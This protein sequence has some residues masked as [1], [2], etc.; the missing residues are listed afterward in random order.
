MGVLNRL[1]WL[2]QAVRR[3]QKRTTVGGGGVPPSAHAETHEDGGT[4]EIDILALAGYPDPLD[5]SVVL[6]G[7]RTFGPALGASGAGQYVPS[8]NGDG[9]VSVNSEGHVVLVWW[10]GP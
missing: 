4:D 2:E 3:L 9:T 6:R 5:G 7:N 10:E 1:E 8:M